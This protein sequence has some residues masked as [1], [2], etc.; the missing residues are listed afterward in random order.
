[1]NERYKSLVRR[2]ETISQSW[3]NV[4]FVAGHEHSIQ[5]IEKDHIKQIVSGSGS[6]ANYAGLSNTGLFA[7]SDLGFAALDIFKDGSSW[8]SFYGSEDNK[9][10][11]LYQKEIFPKPE[12]F[13][14]DTLATSFPQQIAAS[15]YELEETE[16]GELYKSVW[17]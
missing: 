17:G 14:T 12:P 13:N 9:P 10:K 15:I 11:L 5:Y 4:V 1:Q 3:G 2:L 7:Y 6:K 8:V 16:K